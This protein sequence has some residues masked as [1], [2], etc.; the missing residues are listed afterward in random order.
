MMHLIHHEQGA[1]AAEF[2]QMQVR[3]RRDGLVR[4]DVPGQAPA[5]V[6]FVVGCTNGEGVA[7]RGSPDRVGKRFLRLE[8]E[9]VAGHDPANPLDLAGLDQASRS[10]HREEGLAAARRHGRQDVGDLLSLLR[11]PLRQ[12]GLQEPADAPAGAFEEMWT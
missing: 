12:Q 5:G 6:W 1:M 4:G 3:C 11:A 9:A 7:E 2:G 10:N 8:A